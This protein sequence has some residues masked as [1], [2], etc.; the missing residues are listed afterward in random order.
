MVVVKVGAHIRLFHCQLQ[1]IMPLKILEVHFDC[2][3]LH[4]LVGPSKCFPRLR[5]WCGGGFSWQAQ[6]NPY[7][8]VD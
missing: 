4:I 3:G 5:S 6:R 2:A 1:H 7:V 8:W